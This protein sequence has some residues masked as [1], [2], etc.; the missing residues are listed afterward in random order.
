MGMVKVSNVGAG[1]ARFSLASHVADEVGPG[2]GAL[3]RAM[4]L[5][6]EA[7]GDGSVLYQGSLGGLSRIALGQIPPGGERTYRFTVALP[8]SVGNEVEGSSMSAGFSWNAA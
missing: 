1:V 3:S 8:G 6:I 5:R 7:A 4:T 2:G